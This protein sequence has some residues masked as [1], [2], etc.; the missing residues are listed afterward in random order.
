MEHLDSMKGRSLDPPLPL[1]RAVMHVISAVAFGCRFSIEDENFHRLIGA[2][3]DI[4]AFGNSFYYYR[5]SS[6]SWILC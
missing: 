4:I 6:R 5:K 2:T 1:G 3:D